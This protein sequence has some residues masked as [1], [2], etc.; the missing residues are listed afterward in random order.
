V[1]KQLIIDEEKIKRTNKWRLKL[2]PMLD[3]SEGLIVVTDIR[4][5]PR[6]N[7]HYRTIFLVKKT[8]SC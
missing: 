2:I 6:K 7:E 3:T 8:S 1:L 5:E 4:M